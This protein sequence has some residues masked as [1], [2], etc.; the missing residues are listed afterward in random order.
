MAFAGG[1]A[2]YALTAGPSVQ[3]QSRSLEIRSSAVPSFSAG[4]ET[5][6]FGKLDYVGGFQYSSSDSRLGGVSGIRLLEGRSRFL[7]VTDTGYWFRGSIA[8]DS[9]GRPMGFENAEMAPILGRDGQSRTRRKGLADAEGLALDGDRAIVAFERYHRIESFPNAGDPA[10]SRPTDIRQ[11]IPR[12]ELRINAGI[13][14]I[15]VAP[16]GARGGP[17]T[18]IVTEQS[19][20]ADGNLFAAIIGE[21]GGLFKVRREA[22]WN[23]TDAAF[24]PSGDLLLLERRYESFGRLGM[25]IRRIPGDAIRPGALVDGEVLID[26]DLG[27]EIDNMEGIDVSTGTD[28]AIYVALV[29]DDNTSFLQR[30]LYLEFRF[31]EDATQ[32][33][34]APKDRASSVN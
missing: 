19:I 5:R 34:V 14:A 20:D 4:A 27:E 23:A 10:D 9:E 31:V 21:E 6:R 33:G 7:A 28:G 1:L 3:S 8:R 15:A 30:N 26:A 24:L 13:E 11:P 32:S 25:R 17:R 22:P 16:A 12:R 2:A 29:S 18:V